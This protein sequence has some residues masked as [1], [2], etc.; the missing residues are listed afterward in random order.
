MKKALLVVLFLPFTLL[1]LLGNLT[2]LAWSR[3][4]QP[5]A[6]PLSASPISDTNFQLTASAGTAQVLGAKVIPGDARG[7]LLHSFL[8]RHDSPMAPYAEYLVQQADEYAID[9]R[10]VVV[11]AMCESNLGKR[12]PTRDS[13]NAWGIAV[14]TGKQTGATFDNWEEAINWVSRYIK[15]KYYDRGIIDLRDIGAI[16][17]PPSVEKGYSW[18]NCVESFRGTIL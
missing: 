4:W 17:A 8:E 9:F 12:M 3:T 11:I 14:Y 7:L 5:I 13:Y 16:W 2:V 18:T 1:F 10:L 15:Q 6:A